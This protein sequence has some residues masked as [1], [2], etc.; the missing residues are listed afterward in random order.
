MYK[1]RWDY[2]M[3]RL[4]KKITLKEMSKY[5]KCSITLLSKYENGERNMKY[6]KVEDYK[7]YIENTDTK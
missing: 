4:K 1:D 5:I 2:K 7:Y 3:E 6:E